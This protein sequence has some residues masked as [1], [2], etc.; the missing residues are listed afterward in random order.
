ML[1]YLVFIQC[2]TIFVSHL[3]PSSNILAALLMTIVMMLLSSVSGLMVHPNNIPFY[4]KWLGIISPEKWLL[5]LLTKD[6]YS[7]EAIATYANLNNCR[8]KQVNS[9]YCCSPS[10]KKCILKLTFSDST[11]RD[12]CATTMSSA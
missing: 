5:P 10:T 1:L 6:E 8:N 11:P 12:Y 7:A 9:N 2:L 3:L 4:L